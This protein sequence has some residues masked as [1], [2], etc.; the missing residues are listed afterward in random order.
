MYRK[1]GKHHQKKLLG[2]INSVKLQ[3]AKL[4]Y[5]T[6]LCLYINSEL[7]EREINKAVSFTIV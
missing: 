7:S 3:D 1:L 6:L 4:I 5:E 2:L